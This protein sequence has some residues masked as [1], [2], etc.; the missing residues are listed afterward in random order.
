MTE[1]FSRLHLPCCHILGVQK[2]PAV[3]LKTSWW[4]ALESKNAAL[5]LSIITL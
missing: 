2:L 4:L 1:D 3:I 5:S